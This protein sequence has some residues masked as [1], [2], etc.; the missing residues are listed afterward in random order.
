MRQINTEEKDERWARP[1]VFGIIE[2]D[3]E[4]LFFS[5][6]SSQ[7]QQVIFLSIEDHS[8][9]SLDSSFKDKSNFRMTKF[10]LSL[11]KEYSFQNYL[12]CSSKDKSSFLFK[13]NT[14]FETLLLVLLKIYL[15]FVWQKLFCLF[16]KNIP[17]KLLKERKS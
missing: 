9:A 17:F 7:R 5:F 12:A 1:T 14:P 10:F 4:K 16:M 3:E 13:K 8:L 6:N 11:Q 2:K 15:L